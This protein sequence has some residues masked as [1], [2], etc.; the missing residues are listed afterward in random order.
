MLII[1]AKGFAKEVLEVLHQ[2]GETKNLFF[3]DDISDGLPEK[4]YE[5]FEIIKDSRKV[6]ELFQEDN[7]FV[8]GLGNPTNRY[9]LA[10]QFISLG[11]ELTS[12]I[13][14]FAHI[15]H[16]GTKIGRGSN[17]MTG[18]IITNDINI[19]QGCLIN[20]DCT[21]GHDTIIGKYCELSPSVNISG[22]CNIGDFCNIGTGAIIL[23]KVTIGDNVVIGAGAV[24]TK[25]IESNSLAVGVPAKVVKKLEPLVR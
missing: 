5:Q 3:F 4:L 12:V 23:P 19:G 25:D 20:L 9:R 14:P 10:Q 16:Y 24:V 7:R 18:T 17:I 6:V 21:V 15:G 2:I 13:S 8:L 22:N 1:G 11:G